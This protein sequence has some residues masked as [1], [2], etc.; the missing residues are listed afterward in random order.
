MR[1]ESRFRCNTLCSTG[2]Q[3]M[4]DIK[5]CSF[6]PSLHSPNAVPTMRVKEIPLFKSLLSFPLW[7]FHIYCGLGG[8]FQIGFVV[9]FFLPS[10]FI[11][12]VLLSQIRNMKQKKKKGKVKQASL[13]ELRAV[14]SRNDSFDLVSTRNVLNSVAN[15]HFGEVSQV[16]VLHLF[17]VGMGGSPTDQ[18]Q[19]ETRNE[20]LRLTSKFRF[21]IE[22]DF[23][24]SK[25]NSAR[26]STTAK[27]LVISR[28]DDFYSYSCCC[29]CCCTWGGSFCLRFRRNKFNFATRD[30]IYE[31]AVQ[32]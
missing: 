9:G 20:F 25:W 32:N 6:L 30:W 5:R 13:G 28:S 1:R 10:R 12:L 22:P 24:R 3:F 7:Q 15:S 23:G 2:H 19:R 11:P 18:R 29:C 26:D 16:C 21:R 8:R 17:R 31:A 14:H 4:S 27:S